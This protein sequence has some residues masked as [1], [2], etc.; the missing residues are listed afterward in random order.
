MRHVATIFSLLCAAA[1]TTPANAQDAADA[2]YGAEEMAAARS[3]LK[4]DVGGQTNYFV[5]AERLEV[6]I[7]HGDPL[8]L[9]DVQGWYGGD[10]RKLWIKTEGEYLFDQDRFEEAEVQVLYSHAIGPFFDVQAGLRHDFEPDPSR[11]F[12]V[13]GVQGTAPY[14]FEVDAAAFISD[15][16]DVSARIEAEYELLITQRLIAQPR[17][18]LNFAAQDVDALNIGA[19]LSTAELGM[20]LRYEIKREV[21][22]YIG[23]SWSRSVGETARFARTDGD[24]VSETAFVAGLRLWF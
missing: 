1:L 21:A 3:A 10:V 6:Q 19:G 13:I 4:K 5:Q 23:I 12:A 20:R 18:E 14:W 7:P 11:S 15:D 24:E 9:W 2:Y 17:L 22:P 16:G 8:M